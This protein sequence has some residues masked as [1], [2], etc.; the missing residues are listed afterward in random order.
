[1]VVGLVGWRL[2]V[3]GCVKVDSV[4]VAGGSRLN[5]GARREG[6]PRLWRG[7]WSVLEGAGQAGMV[8]WLK[9][10]AVVGGGFLGDRHHSWHPVFCRCAAP[11][12]I[13]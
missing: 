12:K 2:V 8:R 1:M 3:G 13:K 6:C 7:V 5:I 4:V 10:I 9:I 11:E